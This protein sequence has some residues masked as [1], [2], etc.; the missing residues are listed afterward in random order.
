MV[1]VQDCFVVFTDD[2]TAKVSLNLVTG[3][4]FSGLRIIDRNDL[5]RGSSLAASVN[6]GGFDWSKD[7]A[8]RAARTAGYQPHD[9]AQSR[10]GLGRH[11]LLE[12]LRRSIEL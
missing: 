12:H 3:F 10:G 8:G 9:R 2:V 5:L 7:T 11:H 1:F 4:C 6:A